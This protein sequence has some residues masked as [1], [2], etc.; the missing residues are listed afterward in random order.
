MDKSEM[1]QLKSDSFTLLELMINKINTKNE[2]DNL[3]IVV[4]KKY[5]ENMIQ[6]IKHEEV[7]NR[8]T[9]FIE[10]R[11]SSIAD[12]LREF[13]KDEFYESLE[14]ECFYRVMRI[15]YITHTSESKYKEFEDDC[16]FITHMNNDI[17]I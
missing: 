4:M 16:N 7:T 2:D 13:K 8:Y 9:Y 10:N 15:I 5:Y 6:M 11:L 12:I 14:I 3:K 17:T 1:N